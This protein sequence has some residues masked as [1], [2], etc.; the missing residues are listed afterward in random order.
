[1]GQNGHSV[2]PLRRRQ[3]RSAPDRGG[4]KLVLGR[5]LRGQSRVRQR[6]PRRLREVN[7]FHPMRYAVSQLTQQTVGG[8]CRVRLDRDELRDP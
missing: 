8:A 7:G 5:D 2:K 6:L 3:R 4:P 1:M